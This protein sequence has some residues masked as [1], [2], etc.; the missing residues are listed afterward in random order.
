[1]IPFLQLPRIHFEFGAV[2]A[3]PTELDS[4]RIKRP[5]FVTDA[6]LIEIGVFDQARIALPR[7]PHDAV[8]AEVPE[9]PTAAAVED[10]FSVYR[11]Q[12]CDGIVAIGGGSVIDCAKA[13]AVLGTHAGPI[14]PYLGHPERITRSLAPL[15]AIPT[16]AGTGSEVSRGCGI[17]PDSKSRA[18]GINHPFVVPLVAICDPTL[19]LGLPPRLTAGTGLDALSHCIEG[20]LAAPNNQLVDA[21]AIDGVR[22]LLEFLPRAVRDGADRDARYQVMLGAI[23]GGVSIYKG[24][25]P[26]HAFANTC[27]DRGLH[28][29]LLATIALPTVLRLYQRNGV[30]RLHMLAAFIGCTNRVS[31]AEAVQQL[32]AELGVPCTIREL[33]YHSVDLDEVA[34]DATQSFF[35][36]ASTYRP[37]F[38]EY[39]AMAEELLV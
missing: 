37:T 20:F 33:G 29:G 12:D 18:S 19:T 17:H 6:N 23:Q 2:A 38:T 32:N 7:P 8:F 11:D 14:A 28:H 5:L 1:M 26:A 24:L 9:N 10:C 16:T 30:E 36:R 27:G 4:L 15:I 39:R 22:R 21:I 13:V 35:N 3:L 31:V 34:K 25:G